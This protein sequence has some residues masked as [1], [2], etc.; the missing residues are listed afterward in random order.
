M[1]NDNQF[2]DLAEQLARD[3]MEKMHRLIAAGYVDLVEQVVD[4]EIDIDTAMRIFS[5]PRS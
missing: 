1:K 5:G 2:R 3:E 4:G